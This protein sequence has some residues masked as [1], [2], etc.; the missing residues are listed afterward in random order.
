MSAV[1]LSV[2]IPVYGCPEALR[3]LH[4]R[5]VTSLEK[6]T[7]SF[8]IVLVNDDCP[9][10]SWDVMREIALADTR[11]KAINL[12]R[13]FGQIRAITAGLHYAE[14]EWI[15]VMDCDLQ[16]RPEEILKLYNRAQ[17]GYDVVLSRRK[18]RKDSFLKIIGSKCFYWFYNYFTDSQYDGTVCNF[19]ISR[20]GV[21][22][23]YIKMREQNRA[24]ILF[25]KWMGYKQTT[26][27]IEH[28]ARPSGKSGYNMR[29]R[30]NLAF[31]IIT[32]QSNKPLL[33][34]IRIGF[35]SALFSL[36]YAMYLVSKYF[37]WGAPPQG[38]TTIVVSVYFV[39]GL[40]LMN[41]G[42]LGLYIGYLFNEAKGRPLFIVRDSVINGHHEIERD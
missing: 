41:L 29:R 34:S 37:F 12:S 5:L 11:V 39:G 10:N 27:D 8:E 17:E 3:E 21:I 4:E 9:R 18:E 33:L 42:L 20:R 19:S 25:L 26:I 38:W 35:L 32:A 23:N 13:N 36:L 14:G 6:I 22:K 7:S 40:I 28:S 16:D 31:E 2:V 15:V 1:D 30:I 24:F